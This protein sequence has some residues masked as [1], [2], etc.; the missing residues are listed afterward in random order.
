MLIIIKLI[1]NKKLILGVTIVYDFLATTPPRMPRYRLRVG[2]N[3]KTKD[4][5]S[6]KLIY[7]IASWFESANGRSAVRSCQTKRFNMDRQNQFQE[8]IS[9]EPDTLSNCS[10]VLLADL[11][12]KLEMKLKAKFLRIITDENSQSKF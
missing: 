8:S 3:I 2:P 4:E 10:T 12:H 1:T 6:D 5:R 7:E 9:S 11:N